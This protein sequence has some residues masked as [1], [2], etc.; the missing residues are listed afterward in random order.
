M[1]N[2][3]RRWFSLCEKRLYYFH[4]DHKPDSQP[5]GVV[6]L[7]GYVIEIV[8]DE[9]ISQKL[10]SKTDE[11]PAYLLCADTQEE[12][13]AWISA[14]LMEQFRQYAKRMTIE[15][16][17]RLGIVSKSSKDIGRKGPSAQQ[18]NQVKPAPALT[19]SATAPLSSSS[20]T[21]RDQSPSPRPPQPSTTGSFIRR[22]ET[23]PQTQTCPKCNAMM[24]MN[25]NFCRECGTMLSLQ[26][27]RPT[28]SMSSSS[29]A[30]SSRPSP[31][32]NSKQSATTQQ[33]QSRVL[34][35][36]KPTNSPFLPPNT[37]TS[38]S[39]SSASPLLV[40][41]YSSSV[42]SPQSSQGSL[43]TKRAVWPISSQHPTLQPARAAPFS[44]NQKSAL[45]SRYGTMRTTTASPRRAP[46]FSSSSDSATTTPEARPPQKIAPANSQSFI[47]RPAT[48]SPPDPTQMG[49]RN[50]A[51]TA[52][53]RTISST[54]ASK[55]SAA[56]SNALIATSITSTAA[57]NISK[58]GTAEP[59]GKVREQMRKAIQLQASREKEMR[60]RVMEK[61]DE[62]K[63]ARA[64][65]GLPAFSV[66]P[67]VK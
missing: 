15:Q 47:A 20:G 14:I 11:K 61:M 41:S 44:N 45:A 17:H 49:S 30:V 29:S 8:G 53:A 6:C 33:S 48:T 13:E 4:P 42:L 16:D 43:Q 64:A 36:N 19:R 54:A 27:H 55:T 59:K 21:S 25:A 24:E 34:E 65:A 22:R 26:S 58:P 18:L 2:W 3:K 37:P 10:G 12:M 50:R 1:C 63:R 56:T 60:Q 28:T 9:A 7:E 51:P 40:K 23:K 67:E 52:P 32:S 57:S 46:P 35:N 66:P 38:S 39:S 5:Y 62:K 31:F